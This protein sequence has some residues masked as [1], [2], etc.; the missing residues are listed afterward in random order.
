MRLDN[1]FVGIK[2]TGTFQHSSFLSGGLV[3]SA[4]LIRVRNGQI[5]ALSPLS[6]HYRSSMV[7]ALHIMVNELTNAQES[8]QDILK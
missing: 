8:L 3:A 1:V 7:C 6:G 4:G 2:T 5:T